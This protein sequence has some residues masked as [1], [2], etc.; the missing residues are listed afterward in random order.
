MARTIHWGIIGVGDVTEVKSGPGFQQAENSELVAVMRRNAEKAKDY[1]K[2]HDVPKW[3]DDGSDLINDPDVDAVY[4]AT[5]PN[6]HMEYSIA[7]AQAGKPVYVEKPMALNYAECQHMLQASEEASV[8]LWVAYYRRALPRF[9]RVR[10]LLNSGAI[11]QA[12]F[13]SIRLM[14]KPRLD[15]YSS[16]SLPWRVLPEIAGGGLFVDLAAHTLDI[17]DFLFGPITSVQG[18]ASNQAD[19]YPAEDTVTASF[20]HESGVHGSGVWCFASCENDDLIDI[21]G[22]DGRIALSTFGTE[23]VRVIRGEN[24]TQYPE[25][26]PDHIQQP[27]IQTIVNELNG[28]GVCPSTG[29]SGARTTRVMDQI[30]KGYYEPA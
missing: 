21:V 25:E 7:A 8:P 14:Q 6:A 12:R 4:I 11:G 17:L 22:T 1:A 3:Y 9:L 16:A 23:P 28:E 15:F 13:V 27:L 26:T 18:H 30:L 29:K 19:L 24:V 20:V 5:P 2:R 10:Q